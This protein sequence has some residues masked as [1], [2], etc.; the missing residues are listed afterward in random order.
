MFYAV[1]PRMSLTWFIKMEWVVCRQRCIIALHAH[2]RRAILASSSSLGIWRSNCELL[3]IKTCFCTFGRVRLKSFPLFLCFFK[4]SPFRQP[5]RTF[6]YPSCSVRSPSSNKNHWCRRQKL[7]HNYVINQLGCT[8]IQATPESASKVWARPSWLKNHSGS[9]G[10]ANP[11][12][13]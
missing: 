2:E 4:L 13:L 3:L 12:L 10:L 11:S 9:L 5:L 7:K 6:W 8:W 1:T